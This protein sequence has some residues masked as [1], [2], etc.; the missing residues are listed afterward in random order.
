MSFL[1]K[2]GVRTHPGGL[3]SCGH[4]MFW[5]SYRS[6]PCVDFPSQHPWVTLRV[7]GP[8]SPCPA[9][10]RPIPLLPAAGERLR[11]SGSGSA[12]PDKARIKTTRG[13]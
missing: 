7:G 6:R 2:T 10:P 8:A 12:E 11:G 9:S 4:K 5:C 3:W 1:R 13:I